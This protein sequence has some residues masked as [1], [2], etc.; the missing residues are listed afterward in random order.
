MTN[1]KRLR[2]MYKKMHGFGDPVQYSVFKCDL[3]SAERILLRGAVQ[4]IINQASVE[5]EESMVVNQQGK[6]QL[7]QE[8]QQ[9][10]MQQEMPQGEPSGDLPAVPDPPTGGSSEEV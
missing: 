1:A 8:L 10:E 4:E 6:A 9:Q 3:S 7:I 2:R 5:L